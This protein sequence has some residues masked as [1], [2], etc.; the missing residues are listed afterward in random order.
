MGRCCHQ[1]LCETVHREIPSCSRNANPSFVFLVDDVTYYAIRVQR[2]RTQDARRKTIFTARPLILRQGF[3]G[4]S[5][6]KTLALNF[7][8]RIS[9]PFWLWFMKRLEYFWHQQT[10]QSLLQVTFFS[11]SLFH[12]SLPPTRRNTSYR[13]LTC[14]II[15]GRFLK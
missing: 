12:V 3:R 8:C 6:V 14:F 13:K 15:S 10:V 5:R 11:W 1:L 9:F 4:C 7:Q 2:R